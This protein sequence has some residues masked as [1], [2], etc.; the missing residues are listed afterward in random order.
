MPL[1]RK[2]S[3]VFA[4]FIIVPFTSF[5]HGWSNYDANKTLDYQGTVQEL[6]YENPH[7]T[8][9]VKHDKKVWF[10]FLAPVS[11][12]KDR[13]VTADMVKKGATIRVVGYPHKEIKDEMRAERIFINGNK[14]ELR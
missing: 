13:G 5:H 14:Y 3:L 12:M 1:L 9:K 10:V 7:A 8:V 4:L 6:V 2:I 11:R